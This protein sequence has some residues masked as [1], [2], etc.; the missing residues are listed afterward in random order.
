MFVFSVTSF[1]EAYAFAS[2]RCDILFLCFY[3]NL[4]TCKCKPIRVVQPFCIIP[5]NITSAF[6]TQNICPALAPIGLALTTLPSQAIKNITTT[7]INVFLKLGIIEVSVRRWPSI[8]VLP[9]TIYIRPVDAIT[10]ETCGNVNQASEISVDFAVH[11]GI[12]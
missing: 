12:D 11:F 5:Y 6:Y 9:A 2:T 1:Q 10:A 3:H 7:R 4:Y 8:T